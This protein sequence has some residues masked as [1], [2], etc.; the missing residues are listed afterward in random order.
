MILLPVQPTKT[1]KKHY[2]RKQLQFN[3]DGTFKVFH[4][5]SKQ[6]GTWRQ[7]QSGNLILTQLNGQ[8]NHQYLVIETLKQDTMIALSPQ[9]DKTA[10]THG[11]LG[12]ARFIKIS[13]LDKEYSKL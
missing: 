1:S 11:F 9:Y 10:L 7:S 4:Y 13:K 12:R 8:P 5:Y 6:S 3:K 2:P